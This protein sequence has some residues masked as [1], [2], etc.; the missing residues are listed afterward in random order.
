MRYSPNKFSIVYFSFEVFCTVH[1]IDAYPE[2]DL[3]GEVRVNALFSLYLTRAFLPQLR[4]TPGPVNVIFVGSV[5]AEVRVLRLSIDGPSKAFLYQLTRC[6]NS[7]ERHWEPSNVSFTYFRVGTVV[8]GG[9]RPG[10]TPTLFIPA[11]AD[12]AKSVVARI[13]CGREI[14]PLICLTQSKCGVPAYWVNPG[15]SSLLQTR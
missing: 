1:R 10:S 11:A 6:L 5:G 14:V 12:F 7:D 3:M 8:T 13:G 4:A 15:L 9:F 2:E